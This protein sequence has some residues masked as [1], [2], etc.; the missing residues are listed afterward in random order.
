VRALPHLD[1]QLLDGLGLGHEVRRSRDVDGEPLAPAVGQSP[2]QVF[3]VQDATYVVHGVT[4]DGQPRVAGVRDDLD[5]LG[6]RRCV[7][8]RRHVGPGDHHLTN[9]LLGE[10]GDRLEQRL[11]GLL[12]LRVVIGVVSAP[13]RGHGPRRERPLSACYIDRPLPRRTQHARDRVDRAH[14]WQHDR[15][16]VQSDPLGIRRRDRAWQ[17]LRERVDDKRR[18]HHRTRSGKRDA[19]RLGAK[20]ALCEPEQSD[21]RGPVCQARYQRAC[22]TQPMAVLGKRVE[23]CRAG[24]LGLGKAM[25][26]T[27]RQQHHCGLSRREDRA[28]RGEHDTCDQS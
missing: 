19:P 15:R 3:R 2:E 11:L 24:L 18:D 9:D 6:T 12:T 8:Q 23:C 14:Q 17:R 20:E 26:A 7:G 4:V 5:C 25:D 27:G 22:R 28:E 16:R 21:C 10:V 13:L 1:E